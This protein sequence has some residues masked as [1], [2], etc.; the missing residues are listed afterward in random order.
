MINIWAVILCMVLSVV[1]GSIW[2]GPLFGKKWMQL[3]GINMPADC[4]PSMSLMIKPMILSLIGAFLMSSVLTYSIV[5]HN[6][7]FSTSGAGTAMSFAF[8]LWLGFFVPVYLN[9]AGWEGKPKALFFI[10][11]GY[12]LVFMLLASS[13]I[14]GF[15]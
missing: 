8:V 3:S 11:S 13:I 1:L 15:M 7:Y 12:W 4:K 9:F 10:N 2:Y 6:A 14:S 5:F